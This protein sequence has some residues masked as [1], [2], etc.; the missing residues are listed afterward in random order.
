MC[1]KRILEFLSAAVEITVTVSEV[2]VH[3]QKQEQWRKT[4]P[5]VAI[6]KLMQSLL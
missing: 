4:V 6:Q 5:S 2:L 3:L 1:T